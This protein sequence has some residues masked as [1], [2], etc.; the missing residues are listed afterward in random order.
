M[1]REQQK[2]KARR[3]TKERIRELMGLGCCQAVISR[4]MNLSK[5]TIKNLQRE[6]GLPPRFPIVR[7][8]RTYRKKS[9]AKKLVDEAV[10]RF[11]G[12]QLPADTDA[13]I[14]VMTDFPESVPAQLQHKMNAEQWEQYRAHLTS[15][16]LAAIRAR[17]NRIHVN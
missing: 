11:F 10:E 4:I 1:K 15:G 7:S 8:K 9:L 17:E 12:G 3:Q 13:L 14:K 2:E 6:M 16:I 5:P